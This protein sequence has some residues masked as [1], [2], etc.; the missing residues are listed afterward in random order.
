MATKHTRVSSKGARDR[1]P[2]PG[3]L[4]ERTLTVVA[5]DITEDRRRSRVANC[6]L[7]YGG[8][9]EASVY[10]LWLTTRQLER[11]W[12]EVLKLI[13]KTDLVRCY[14]LCGSCKPKIRSHAIVAPAEPVVFIV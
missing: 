7:S 6:L 1:V 14:T 11:M 3:R 13:D 8:R 10:E 5:Y 9:V 12:E 2:P 4:D